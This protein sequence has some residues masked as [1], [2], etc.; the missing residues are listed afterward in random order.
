MS[1]TIDKKDKILIDLLQL[2]SDRSLDYLAEASGLSVPS[3]QRRL[4]KLK[5]KKVIL[6]EIAIIDPV[7]V[8]QKMTFIITVGLE[9]ERI[10][11]LDAFRRKV[12][13]ESQV[14][15]CYYVTGESDFV[16]IVIAKDMADFETF[17]RRLFFD[18]ENIRYFKTSVVMDRTKVGL[19]IPIE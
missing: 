9:R 19:S 14:Q 16:L 13:K 17:T 12:K 8:D 3:V 4:R 7:S 15:Q 1:Y 11:K 5:D 10:D 2:D 6:G 18:D